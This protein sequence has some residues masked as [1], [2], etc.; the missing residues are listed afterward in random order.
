MTEKGGNDGKGGNGEIA[1]EL[2]LLA[3]TE[4]G[5]RF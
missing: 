2:K 4:E 5:E 3:M 1:S